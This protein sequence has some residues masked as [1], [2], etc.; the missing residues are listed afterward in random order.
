LSFEPRK[1]RE[2]PIVD[3]KASKEDKE[4]GAKD[5]RSKGYSLAWT[6]KRLP[7]RE[8][9]APLL[10][11]RYRAHRAKGGIGSIPHRRSSSRSKARTH[12]WEDLEKGGGLET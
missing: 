11:I 8:D 1:E 12:N 4:K 2:R 5:R 6:E 7:L 9:E 10:A 3:G